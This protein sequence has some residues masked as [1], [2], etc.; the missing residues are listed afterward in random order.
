MI[1]EYFG[2]AFGTFKE[3]KMRTWLTMLGIFIGIAA[4]VALLSLGGGLQKAITEQFEMM[5]SDKIMVS[6]G[7]G[8]FGVGGGSELDKSDL[9]VIA[10]TK[11]VDTA[12]GML[13]KIAKLEFKDDVKYSYVMGI[14][15]SGKEKE[16][17]ESM[18]SFTVL[19]GRELSDGDK[20]K[21]IVGIRHYEGDLFEK[22]V[23]VRDKITVEGKEFVVVGILSRVGNP[24]DDSNVYIPI[25]TAREL[26]DEPDI[27]H[28]LMANTLP[29]EDVGAV[30]EAVKKALR[31]HRD[32]QEGEEDF[33]VQTSQDLAEVFATVFT[34]V[35]VVLIGIAFISLFVGGIGIMNTM[36]TSVLQRTRDI[37]IMKAI[38]A[39]NSDIMWIFLIES[40][41]LGLAG[42]IVG[43]ALGMGLSTM[44]GNL[45]AQVGTTYL[46]PDFPWYLIVG[47]LVF[48][49]VV[50]TVSGVLPAI[51]AAKMN[52]VDAL[53]Y[54]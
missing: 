15:L 40:G 41:L 28:F 47:S 13:F 1:A 4:V 24:E 38:G 5:G 18:Q 22:P 12:T 31:K 35:Q 49:F 33:Q 52:P 10:R 34:I 46:H 37:G 53:R 27:Y 50:G 29:G 26:F 2:F 45:A 8:F 48:S 54:E 30:A 19:E 25:D 7:G 17:I 14:P 11:G 3:R 23:S 32:V 43:V 51:Q 6:P 44:V 42:G 9:Q 20:Y 16:I 39:R 36:Y 21:A